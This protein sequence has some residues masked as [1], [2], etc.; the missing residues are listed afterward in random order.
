MDISISKSY[1]FIT[2]LVYEPGI[3]RLANVSYRCKILGYHGNDSRH[4]HLG[5]NAM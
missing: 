2:I 4:G 1:G 5:C 3:L